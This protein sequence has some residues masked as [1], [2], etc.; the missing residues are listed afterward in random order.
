MLQNRA[1][2]KQIRFHLLSELRQ[3]YTEN[4]SDSIVRLIME[5]IGYPLNVSLR[6]P[7]RIPDPPLATQ[8]N[9]I[10]ADIH[11]GQPIQYILGYTYFCDLKIEVD[12]RVLIPRPE[13]EALVEHI[14][15]RDTSS[16][17]RIIDLATGSGCIA[18]ALKQYF[19]DAEVWGVD[20]SREA[21][22]KAAEN[23][24]SNKLKVNW[25]WMDLLDLQSIKPAEPFDLVVSNPPYVLNREANIMERHITDF[26]PSSALFVPDDDPLVFYRAI[27]SFCNLHLADKGEI[28]VEINEQFGKETASVFK[29]EGFS[30]VQVLTDIH[31]KERYIHASR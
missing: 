2:L 4:E 22:A 7:D 6:D 14:K 15:A 1:T 18:L 25:A 9:K 16:V 5:D 20:L 23:S 17:H 8:I 30:R 12:K 21:L 29:K 19:T 3:R 28:W 24:S 31:N 10:I 27:V 26:E 13:T 11:N